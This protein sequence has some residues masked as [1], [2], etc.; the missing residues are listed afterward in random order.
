MGAIAA[1]ADGD[2]R[3]LLLEYVERFALAGEPLAVTTDRTTFQNW[4]GRRVDGGIGGAYVYDRRGG[5]HLVLINLPRIDRSRPRSVEIVVAEELMHMRD[6]IDG[7]RRRHAKHGYDR[8]A[9]RV[10]DVT[11]ASLDEV[12]SC[13]LP[14]ER[15]PIRYVYRCPGCART[16]ERRRKGTWSCARCSPTFDRRYVLVLERDLG[17]DTV[18]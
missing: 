6:W 2:T 10:A 5:R 17:S 1:I 9:V 14:R 15:R 7:D 18:V 3:R 4:L 8:I 12:R 13:L 16:V 11:G